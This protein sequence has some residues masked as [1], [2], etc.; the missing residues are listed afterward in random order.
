MNS[1]DNFNAT[2][3]EGMEES[4]PENSVSYEDEPGGGKTEKF[5]A[6]TWFVEDDTHLAPAAKKPPEVIHA[7]SKPADPAPANPA[8]VYPSSQNPS[9]QV[10]PEKETGS[11]W[12]K[13]LLIVCIL[14]VVIGMVAGGISFYNDYRN[15]SQ[16]K[17]QMYD[18]EHL[19]SIAEYVLNN[20]F[21]AAQKEVSMLSENQKKQH[22]S[23]WISALSL[24]RQTISTRN[25]SRGADVAW[26][27]EYNDLVKK[28]QQAF[29]ED[30]FTDLPVELDAAKNQYFTVYSDNFKNFDTDM[31]E[32]Y[33]AL[34][35]SY[36]NLKDTYDAFDG[37]YSFDNYKALKKAKDAY[38]K[39]Y[40]SFDGDRLPSSFKADYNAIKN[41]TQRAVHDVDYVELKRQFSDAQA[42]FV[43]YY[44]GIVVGSVWTDRQLQQY[45][46]QTL[47]A[48]NM[49]S[50]YKD[51]LIVNKF[52]DTCVSEANG[53]QADIDNRSRKDNYSAEENWGYEKIVN[54]EASKYN[55][56]CF[57]NTKDEEATMK[58]ATCLVH[59]LQAYLIVYA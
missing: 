26:V 22:I 45:I 36:T 2:K 55:P 25:L 24:C 46:D 57:Y 47:H 41:A 51:C 21:D 16:G 6:D 53:R 5:S 40:N 34:L 1:K 31:T 20:D 38:F 58:N 9:A 15:S 29:D 10:P 28:T 59:I 44:N 33:I 49:L 19:Q 13:V 50:N 27:T 3:W 54:W 8:P 42:V 4:P 17:I 7:A 37:S 23:D 12:K 18:S 30:D 48:A 43:F 11:V 56:L 35:K 14:L 52:I 39:Q 32:K